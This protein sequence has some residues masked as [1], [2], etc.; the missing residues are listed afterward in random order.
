MASENYHLVQVNIAHALAE[1]ND[2]IMEGFASR[3]DEINAL[4]ERSPGF[5]WRLQSDSGNATDI[6]A[7]EDPTLLI[8]MSVWTSVEA[9]ERYVYL[10]EH[11]ALMRHRKQWFTRPSGPHMVLWWV[12]GG[13]IP[14]IDDAKARLKLLEERGPSIDAF[15]FRERFP[16]PD[17]FKP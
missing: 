5:V 10:G 6:L 1:M 4:A 14:S 17:Q 8:N 16:P 13:E 11:I 2:P 7:F 12:A 3:L 9:L 15:T